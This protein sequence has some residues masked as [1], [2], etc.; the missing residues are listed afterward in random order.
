MTVQLLTVPETAARLRVNRSTVYDLIAA[1]E[2]RVVDLGHG[3]SK[4][5]IPEDALA[6]FI[7]ARTR[8]A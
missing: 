6:E 4:T 5:R 7:A 2:L 8:T 1:G 3:R